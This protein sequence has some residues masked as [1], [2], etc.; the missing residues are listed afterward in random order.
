LPKQL[1]TIVFQAEDATS[2][3]QKCRRRIERHRHRPA[4]PSTA[5]ATRRPCP[6]SP[7]S[8]S[9]L[10]SAPSC[11]ASDRRRHQVCPVLLRR[12]APPPKGQPRPASPA[13]DAATRS[14]PYCIADDRR[15][16]QVGPVLHRPPPISPGTLIP[17]HPGRRY[18]LGLV[19]GQWQK[20][21]Y[22][23]KSWQP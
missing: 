22:F 6:A 13:S 16:N 10:K 12:R 14:T 18:I 19:H 21:S 8:D 20:S 17:K 2:S 1:D 7:E 11:I 15:R 23:V 4:S 9:A 5:A 3:S